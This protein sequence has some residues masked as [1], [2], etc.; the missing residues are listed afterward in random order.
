MSPEPLSF[1]PR[2]SPI[3]VGRIAG[4][5][6]CFMGAGFLA[7]AILQTQDNGGVGLLL[8]FSLFAL[9]ACGFGVFLLFNSVWA[10][11][12]RAV[13][14]PDALH[15][16]AHQGRHAVLTRG[17]R[18][19]AIPWPDIQGFSS[20]RTPNPS[21]RGNVQKTYILYTSQGDFTLN[22]VQW[23]NLDALMS[24]IS[25]RTGRPAEEVAPQRAQSRA[26]IRTT[27]RRIFSMQRLIGWIAVAICAPMLI[28]VLIA[29]TQGF[30]AGL[31]VSAVYLFIGA[32]LGMSLIRFHRK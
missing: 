15:L 19:A 10:S 7:I 9:G 3:W 21:A 27:E 1:G 17:L 12:L 4:V 20:F 30:S 16:I 2:R 31:G 5:G 29:M 32:S 22:D 25:K 6:A 11:R 8:F 24:E 26:E 28:L 23:E 13:V 14:Q 18:E